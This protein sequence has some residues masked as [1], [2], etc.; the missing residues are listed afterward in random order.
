MKYKW[1]HEDNSSVALSED[2]L[3][4]TGIRLLAMIMY[5]PSAKGYWAAYTK[6]NGDPQFLGPKGLVLVEELAPKDYWKKRE[7][8]V[9]AIDEFIASGKLT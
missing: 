8:A 6:G 2:Y 3:K 9:K 7:D 1:R 4:K 5:Q